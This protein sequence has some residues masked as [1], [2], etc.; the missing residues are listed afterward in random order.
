MKYKKF[1]WYTF[2]GIS[3]FWELKQP[4]K[5]KK[6]RIV[7]VSENL[8]NFLTEHVRKKPRNWI[9]FRPCYLQ[10]NNLIWKV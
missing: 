5:V 1:Q 4:F 3:I 9:L 6:A 7:L 2:F 10:L 8:G